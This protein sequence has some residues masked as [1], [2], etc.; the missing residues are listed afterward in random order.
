M[1]LS[2]MAGTGSGKLGSMVYAT[3]AGEQIVRQYQP[4]VSNPSTQG[5]VEQ[6]SKLKLMS[7]VARALSPVIAIPKDG[8]KSSRNLFIKKNFGLAT[9]NAQDEAE[10]NII[11]VQLTPGIDNKISFAASNNTGT[12]SVYLN[13][14]PAANITRIVSVLYRKESDGTLTYIGSAVKNTPFDTSNAIA[15]WAN[16]GNNNFVVYVYGMSDIDA[17][18]T[19]KFAN[20]QVNDAVTLASL[21]ATRTISLAEYSFTATAGQAI[22]AGA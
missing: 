10:V 12:I 7:Q 20:Y 6:R 22:V 4:Q 14:M 5:Q 21:V 18:A 13:D 8:M 16:Q 17:R 15:T 11:N 19:A 1:K 9:I 2:G 3:V